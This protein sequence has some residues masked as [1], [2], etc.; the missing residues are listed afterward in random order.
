MNLAAVFRKQFKLSTTEHIMIIFK[1]DLSINK[2][3]KY[4]FHGQK[5]VWAQ[6]LLNEFDK[7]LFGVNI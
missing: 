2:S 5:I 1:Y 3:T 6:K 7:T 4:N